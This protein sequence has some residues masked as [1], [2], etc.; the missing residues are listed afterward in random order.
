MYLYMVI[1]FDFVALDSCR[2]L[3]GNERHPLIIYGAE[4]SG[5]TCLLARAAQQCRHSWQQPDLDNSLE[6]GVLL[7]FARLTPESSSVLTILHSLT[8]QLSLLATG[9]LLRNPHVK[10][11]LLLTTYSPNNLTRFWSIYRRYPITSRRST[12]CWTTR[13]L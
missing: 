5:K 13:G 3:T 11:T 9:R 7:R 12:G 8:Q 10:I 6:M 4:G 2:Y 1:Y